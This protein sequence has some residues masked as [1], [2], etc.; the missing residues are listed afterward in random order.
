MCSTRSTLSNPSMWSRATS[1]EQSA[2]VGDAHGMGRRRPET[3]IGGPAVGPVAAEHE[4][5]NAQHAY[6]A[7]ETDPPIA[8]RVDERVRIRQQVGTAAGCGSLVVQRGE[9][10]P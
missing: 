6:E 10:G 3:W 2:R 5:I 4:R 1:L 7:V 9:A 8:G